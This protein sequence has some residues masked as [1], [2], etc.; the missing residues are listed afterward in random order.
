MS[1][2]ANR[3]GAHMF[4]YLY[5][6][7]VWVAV[8][9]R[10]T[11]AAVMLTIAAWTFFVSIQGLAGYFEMFP[12]W[13][14]NKTVYNVVRA[15]KWITPKTQDIT[16]L[17]ARWSG[18]GTSFDL[19]PEEIVVRDEGGRDMMARAAALEREQI[20]VS[21]L[22]T[23]GSSLVFEALVL[24]SAIWMFSRKDF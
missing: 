17:A 8:R 24:A 4:S 19:I 12:G 13:Q 3:S 15:A 11:L 1:F 18:A 10:N 5:C 16:Y 2:W 6:I 23:I 22:E 21:A 20:Q 7:S 14:E 9:F